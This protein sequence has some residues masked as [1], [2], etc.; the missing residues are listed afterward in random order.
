MKSDADVPMPLESY[1]FPMIT[2]LSME[3]RAPARPSPKNVASD[4]DGLA[5]ARPSK[6]QSI[7]Q[8]ELDDWKMRGAVFSGNRG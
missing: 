8:V 5:G 2:I 7:S 3:D 6:V 4:R 1:Q